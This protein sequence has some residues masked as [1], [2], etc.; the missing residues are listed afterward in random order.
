MA[1]SV[2]PSAK[3][4]RFKYTATVNILPWLTSLWQYSCSNSPSPHLKKNVFQLLVV[5]YEQVPQEN[6]LATLSEK[7]TSFS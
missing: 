3:S 4:Q 1:F 5:I 6:P 2:S 7:K